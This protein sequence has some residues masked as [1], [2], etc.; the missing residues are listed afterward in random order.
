MAL[1]TGKIINRAQFTEIPMTE[2]VINRVSQLGLSEPAMLTWTNCHGE[3]IGD[4]S[5]WDAMPTS[6]NASNT[7]T[8]EELTEEDD[9]EVSVA[10]GDQED[11]TTELDVVNNIAGV[12][13]VHN[14]DVYKQW[15]KVVPDVGDVNGHIN[16]KVQ[17]VAELTSGG[18]R[19]KWYQ[20]LQ[21]RPTVATATAEVKVSPTDTGRSIREQKAPNPFISSWTG[22]K[23]VY[24]MMQIVKL[25]GNTIEELV[26]FMQQELREAGEHH[27]PEVIGRI[28]VQ[29]SMKAA[30]RELGLARTTKACRIKV[31]QIHMQNIFFPKHWD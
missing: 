4:G 27:R 8:V 18:V 23:Y 16:D 20:P 1:D 9:K 3:N 22:K 15:D 17:V 21:V 13:D 29:L 26:A 30:E 28:M 7:S 14:D 19:T 11:P 12:D 10:E 24:P 2:S 6:Q 31:E 5:L 25:D